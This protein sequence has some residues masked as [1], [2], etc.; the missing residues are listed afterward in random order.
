MAPDLW[1]EGNGTE[2]QMR[3]FA[4]KS[5]PRRLLKAARRRL[6]DE[7][8]LRCTEEG[9]M[10]SVTARRALRLRCHS[11]Q[12]HA[13]LSS[14]GEFTLHLLSKLLELG[15]DLEIRQGGKPSDLFPV[16]GRLP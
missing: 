11:S 15:H 8:R 1:V 16:H 13:V 6:S 3:P 2:S 4:E 12:V 9:V 5:G 10:R 7:L 14:P